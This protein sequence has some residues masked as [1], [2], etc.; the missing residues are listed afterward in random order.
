MSSQTLRNMAAWVVLAIVLFT[1][2]GAFAGGI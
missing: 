2:L 1:S